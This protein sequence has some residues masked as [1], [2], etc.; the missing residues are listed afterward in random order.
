MF[1]FDYT[2]E[3]VHYGSIRQ[4]IWTCLHFP[5]HLAIVLAV[6]GLRQLTTYWAFIES[7]SAVKS[8]WANALVN[9]SD[10]N[11]GV[12]RSMALMREFTTYL[13][14]DGTAIELV[15]N[16]ARINALMTNL[17]NVDVKTWGIQQRNETV[18]LEHYTS[19]AHA[20]FYGMRVP[21]VDP[22]A[23]LHELFGNTMKAEYPVH[24]SVNPYLPI[25]HAC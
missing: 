11:A 21:Y 20:Q 2:P 15:K 10:P 22:N 9:P 4:Q 23:T 8:S 14:D 3:H 5:L 17:T 19:R 18:W 12:R 16:Y 7:R 6:E 25:P 1:Y 13:Y 24:R